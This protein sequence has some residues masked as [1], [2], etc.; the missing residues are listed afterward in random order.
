MQL[1]ELVR[2]SGVTDSHMQLFS[3]HCLDNK[4]RSMLIRELIQHAGAH[5]A[6]R[7]HARH[8]HLREV[9]RNT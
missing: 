4:C 6:G 8:A 5:L 9:L 2:D 1:L 3:L 7:H